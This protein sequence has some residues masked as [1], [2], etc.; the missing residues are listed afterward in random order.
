MDA[1]THFRKDDELV[2]I[3]NREHEEAA[4]EWLLSMGFTRTGARKDAQRASQAPPSD[5]ELPLKG[6]VRDPA[7]D[8][9]QD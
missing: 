1:E 5:S 3:V 2:V 8:P 9:D 4:I 6:E 7:G